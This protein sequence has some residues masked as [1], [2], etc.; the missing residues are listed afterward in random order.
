MYYFKPILGQLQTWV[1]DS[2]VFVQKN[3][4]ERAVLGGAY[5]ISYDCMIAEISLRIKNKS[6]NLNFPV[7]VL[8][9]EK[10]DEMR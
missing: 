4:L 8:I 2:S 6:L 1:R 7:K 10:L 3:C 9:F 5:L